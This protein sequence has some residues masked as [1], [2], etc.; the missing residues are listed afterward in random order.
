MISDFRGGKSDNIGQGRG[1]DKQKSDVL[2]LWTFWHYFYELTTFFKY[3]SIA[4]CDIGKNITT[5]LRIVKYPVLY[6][7]GL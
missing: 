3:S 2:L 4:F 5:L 7:V 6:T 1:V